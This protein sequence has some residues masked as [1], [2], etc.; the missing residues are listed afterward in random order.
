[1]RSLLYSIVLMMTVTAANLHA[2]DETLL[3]HWP[4]WRGPLGNGVAPLADPPVEWGQSK[5]IKWKVDVPGQGSATPIVWGDRM[6]VLTAIP[7]DRKPEQAAVDAKVNPPAPAPL[8]GEGRGEGESTTG[9]GPH[10]VSGETL[11]ETVAF[12]P[13]RRRGGR[14]GGLTREVPENI[15][16]F[17]V[18][19]YDRHTGE[20]L[21]RDVAREEVP[22]EG[23]H[24]TNTYA[25]GSPVTDGKHL[26]VS[27]GSYGIHCYD[28][29]GN[30]QWE[31]DLGRM[32]TRAGF[33]EGTSPVIHGETLVHT[34][35]HEADSFIAALDA[36]TGEVK[37]KVDRD[38]PTTWATPYV[39]E[40]DGRVQ[41]IT[42]GTNRVRSYDLETGELIWECG[43]QKTNPIPSP[44]RLDDLVFCMTG[45][46]GYAV[47]ALPLSA[48]GDITDSDVIAWK[49]SD[50]GPYIS[51]PILYEG[52]LYFTKSREAIL[53]SVDP[54]T[55]ETV[56]GES[57]VANLGT[58]YASPVA[59][60]GKIYLTDRNGRTA[61]LE[62]GRELK[63]LSVNQ[64]DETID[65]SPVLLGNR[66]Y[67]RGETHLY[68]IEEE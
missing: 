7:T 52:Q 3:H 2:D 62:A 26:Y 41:V 4:H 42:S 25:S 54:R 38:E 10:A 17:A 29:E 68:C 22:H 27:F 47:Y 34:W 12:Q 9:D 20:E 18:L 21:W 30:K 33:G 56:I 37:W 46:Q 19:C 8:T 50:A 6:F 13:Q 31:Q 11:S 55:G 23:G 67:L 43:G 32:R 39:T 63:V 15:Y 66:I 57:R 40:Y 5:N 51:S 61:V 60:A 28:L 53:L 35:D 58:L 1:M 65:A 14:R 59:A 45:Y 49:R 24:P 64:L 44:L 48:R 16:E 36:K